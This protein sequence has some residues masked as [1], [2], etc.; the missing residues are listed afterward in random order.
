MLSRRLGKLPPK[1][2]PGSLQLAAYLPAERISI[3]DTLDNHMGISAWGMMANDRLGDCTC[4]AAGHMTQ[5]WTAKNG[6]EAI[7]PD[8]EII[9]AYS[10]VSGYD[11]ATGANDNGAVETE[12][13][14]YWMETGIG[15]HKLDSFAVIETRSRYQLKLAMYLFGDIYT[16]IALPQ[17]AQEQDVW[18]VVHGAEGEPGSWGGHAVPSGKYDA[19]GMEVITWGSTKRMTWAFQHRYMDEAYAP[20]SV[21]WVDEVSRMAPNGLLW[22]QLKADLEKQFRRQ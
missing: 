11:P 19:N 3:P 21:D 2:M 4:A 20:L 15:G 14:K 13:L 10:A 12:V 9:A 16:G 7:I 5:L 22:D 18:S 17:S 1:H 8:D 6:H